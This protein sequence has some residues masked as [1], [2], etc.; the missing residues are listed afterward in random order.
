MIGK[1]IAKAI[2]L[3]IGLLLGTIPVLANENPWKII[4]NIP[5][6]RLCLYH[7]DEIIKTYKV[8]VG[9]IDS[10]S[11]TGEFE[12]IN[13]V[14]NPTWYPE[15]RP[16]VPPGPHNPLGKYWMGLNNKGYGIHG[17]SAAWSIGA[18]ASKG[19]FRMDNH[20]IEE[21]FSL[22][23]VGT[24]VKINYCTVKS[25]IDIDNQ[26]WLEIY[27]DIYHHFNLEKE[28]QRVLDDLNWEYQPHQKAL[29]FLIKSKKPSTE[30]IPRK[31]RIEGDCSNAEIDGFFWNGR[32]YLSK[33]YFET[34]NQTVLLPND[35]LFQEFFV[36]D[37]MSTFE[38]GRE[39]LEW[40]KTLNTL[41]VYTLKA[42]I[43]GE[44]VD[45]ALQFGSGRKIVINYSKICKWFEDKQLPKPVFVVN[46]REGNQF[47]GQFI[48]DEFW[49][50]P[51]MLIIDK[52]AFSY[53]WDEATWTLNLYYSPG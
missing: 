15:G 12:I 37:S 28:V 53:Q 52:S 30:M 23:P 33:N 10:P 1:S 8:A 43:N 14:I 19:C 47:V 51:K 45:G 38:A 16:K 2:F 17:N 46:T 27:P 3:W 13:K 11:P 48:D 50:D 7:N 9:K 40:N 42:L 4:I 22:V 49:V 41:T 35:D 18:P 34:N 20:E 25:K 36:W 5:E 31:I 6:Y 39:K 26:A 21:L 24:S 44:I 32:V 29:A